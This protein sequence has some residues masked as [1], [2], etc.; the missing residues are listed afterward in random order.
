MMRA[1]LSMLLLAVFLPADAG[2]LDT[3]RKVT[4]VRVPG[5]GIQPQ[6]AV[7]ESGA[8]HMIYYQGDPQNGNLYYV[9]SRDGGVSFSAPLRA[10]SSAGSAIAVGNI[11]GGHLAMGKNGR[12][13]VAWNGSR[14]GG[15]PGSEPM[16]YTRL[17]DA[18]T[19]F[20]PQRNVIQSAYGLD[21]GGA[22][23]ADA[24]GGCIRPVA[25]A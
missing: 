5:S 21:G 17:N 13:H 16:L 1:W 11:R 19:A 12:V 9:R 15:K 4:L 20:E 22:V 18:G 6:V 24:S 10:N 25:R 3:S 8:V 14:S 2:E 7:D 23:A